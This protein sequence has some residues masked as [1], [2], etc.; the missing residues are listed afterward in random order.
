MGWYFYNSC[1][2]DNGSMEISIILPCYNEEK[3]IRKAYKETRKEFPNAEIIIFDDNSRDKTYEI[4]KSIKKKDK[5]VTLIRTK[6]RMGRGKSLNY[7]IKKAKGK[8]IFYID[9]D[10]A[11]HPREIKKLLPWL[12]KGYSIVT[13]SRYLKKS[14]AKRTIMRRVLSGG[15]NLLLKLFTGTKLKDHQCGF[16]GFA[17]R[18]ILK[19]IPY[20]KDN[21]WFWDSEIL[22][23][24]QAAGMKV[25]EVPVRWKEGNDTKV[26]FARDILSMGK[27]I[28]RLSLERMLKKNWPTRE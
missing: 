8:F 15:F 25:K 26:N 3:H 2:G 18:D 20:I 9:V 13:G 17:K 28:L 22:I 23:K 19:I 12:K 21:H 24:A 1:R 10:L 4:A 14:K 27:S 11:T 16:K 6:K 7:A 5:K